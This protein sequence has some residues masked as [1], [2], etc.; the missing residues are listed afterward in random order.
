MQT[1]IHE[2]VKERN[3]KVGIIAAIAVGDQ[4]RIGWSKTN[5]KKGDEFDRGEG[6]R[7]AIERA[8]GLQTAPALPSRMRSQMRQFQIR[9][10]RY[11]QQGMLVTM[12]IVNPVAKAIW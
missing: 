2:Y 9:S 5:F 4:I 3:K 8:K 1:M 11:F 12:P 6:M 7:I 10:I